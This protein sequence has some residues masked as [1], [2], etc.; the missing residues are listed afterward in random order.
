VR[1]AVYTDYEYYRVDGEVYAERA[2][3]LFLAE[4]AT[5]LE[6]IVLVGRLDP[7]PAKGRYALGD[8]VSFVPLPFY[9]SL[10]RPLSA[11][12]A[13][14]RSLGRFWRALDGVET[15]W[16]LG[17]HPLSVAFA[18]IAAL[19]R[20]RIV[21]GVRQQY[22]PYVRSRYPDRRLMWAA[23]VPLELAYRALARLV[24]VVAVGP[25]LA[26]HYKRSKK[27][28]ELFVSLVRKDEIL[29][30]EVAAERS[31]QDE[32]VLL[33]VGRLDQEKN[34]LLLADVLEALRRSDPRWRLIVCGEGP[35][36]ADLR[37]RLERLGLSDHAE[38]RGY[39]R[40]DEGLAELY[41]TSHVLVHL[42]WTEGL[43]QVLFEAFAAGLPVVATE[44]G[45][46]TA[47]NSAARLVP[48]GVP[49]AATAEIMRLSSDAGLRA[50][51]VEAGNRLVAEHTLEAESQRLARFLASPRS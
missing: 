3:A 50:R 36:E 43:P 15:V 7:N 42:S 33:S 20:R 26:S 5:R 47:L 1:L 32:L 14:L 34:P 45:G 49:G 21:L 6:G 25:E 46:V 30:P 2:F 38:L 19:R 12:A 23:A 39:L 18:G 35:L 9:R 22:R 31:Y 48:P 51:L 16:L 44:V 28:L 40:H 24:P 17:P 11:S 37:E 27:V 41:R 29:P 10:G 4:L 13:M 8:R